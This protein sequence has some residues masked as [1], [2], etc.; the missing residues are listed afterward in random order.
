[1][2]LFSALSLSL[3]L[4]LPLS[5]S[6][7]FSLT[8]PKFQMVNISTHTQTT[9]PLIINLSS[10]LISERNTSHFCFIRCQ[11]RE[12]FFRELFDCCDTVRTRCT[13]RFVARAREAYKYIYIYK[14][15]WPLSLSWR[16]TSVL[17]LTPGCSPSSAQSRKKPITSYVLWHAVHFLNFLMADRSHLARTRWNAKSV[18]MV[19]LLVDCDSEDTP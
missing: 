19:E 15:H 10:A 9:H 14:H 5:L 2:P 8:L 6:L 17:Y 12:T 16:F 4:S 7:S 13:C 11:K 1:M 18:A 3:S